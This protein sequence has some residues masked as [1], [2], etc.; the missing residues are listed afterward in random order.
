MNYAGCALPAGYRR[1]RYTLGSLRRRPNTALGNNL[2]D[3]KIE[4]RQ[5][6]RQA[7]ARQTTETV[8]RAGAYFY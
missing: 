6:P 8:W 5:R 4:W 1:R 7:R 3:G 2:A